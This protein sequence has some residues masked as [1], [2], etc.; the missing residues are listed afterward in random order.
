MAKELAMFAW[1]ILW[2][3]AASWAVLSAILFIALLAK[4]LFLV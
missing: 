2:R 1:G 3:L 4:Y